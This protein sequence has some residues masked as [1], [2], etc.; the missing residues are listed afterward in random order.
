LQ[1]PITATLKKNNPSKANPDDRLFLLTGLACQLLSLH[2]RYYPFFKRHTL[3]LAGRAL[4]YLKGLFQVPG[5]KN[6]FTEAHNKGKRDLMGRHLVLVG[7]GH[8]HMITLANLHQFMEKGHDVTVIGP[9]PFH[10]YSGMGPGMLGRI[11]RPEEIRF[12]TQQVV[13]KQGGLFIL[14]RVLRVDPQQK[15]LLLESGKHLKYDVVSFNAGSYVPRAD[16]ATDDQEVFTVKPI[17]KLMQA[18]QRLTALFSE[19]I[20]TVAIIGGGAAALEIAGN[21]WR[22]AKDTGQYQPA[23]KLFAGNRFLPSLPPFVREKALKSLTRRGVEVVTQGHVKKIQAGKVI[24]ES[25][26]AHTVDLVFLATGVKPSPI[27]RDSGLPIG[28]DGGLLVNGHLQSTGY[29]EIFGGGDCIHFQ[30]R[31]LDKVGVYAVRQNPVLYH[32][33]MAALEGKP[34]QSFD[35]GGDYMLIFNLGDG[36]GILHKSRLH[37]SGRLAFYIKDYIDRKFMKRFQAVEL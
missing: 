22:L 9:S 36:T 33:L 7:G 2:G 24:P 11:Y 31:P 14:D 26:S 4:Q 23:I 12:A 37:F 35:P 13:E 27:F 19:R 28:P 3:N 5:L 6:L 30:D 29:P 34:L 32:N 16:I 25:G 20:I 10:Y 1:P 21:I 8:A 18:Q 15:V 17:E